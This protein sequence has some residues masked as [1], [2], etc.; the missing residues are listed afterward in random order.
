[1]DA[2]LF[3]WIE[4][5]SPV[6]VDSTGRRAW[7]TGNGGL[8]ICFDMAGH[9]R[10]YHGNNF[11]DSAHNSRRATGRNLC[12]TIDHPDVRRARIPQTLR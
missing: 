3:T 2:G 7:R 8:L 10:N 9:G 6:V 1:M 12:G 11:M 5:L 4:T